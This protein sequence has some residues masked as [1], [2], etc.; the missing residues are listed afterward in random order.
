MEN[1]FY[2]ITCEEELNKVQNMLMSEGYVTP[3]GKQITMENFKN[4][5]PR[6][7]IYVIHAFFNTI[8]KKYE[9]QGGTTQICKSHGY[10]KINFENI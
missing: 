3:T 7:K 5:F 10:D 1:K 8:N 6:N 9:Y 4:A 2:K